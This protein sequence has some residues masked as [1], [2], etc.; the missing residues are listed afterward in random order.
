MQTRSWRRALFFTSTLLEKKSLFWLKGQTIY[1]RKR[2]ISKRH[3]RLYQSG[4]SRNYVQN[5]R[6]W[7]SL[8][9]EGWRS[10]A[11]IQIKGLQGQRRSPGTG[12]SK[13]RCGY[14]LPSCLLPKSPSWRN[15]NQEVR[16]S[17][18]TRT[19]YR[20]NLWDGYDFL[21]KSLI[22]AYGVPEEYIEGEISSQKVWSKGELFYTEKDRGCLTWKGKS[23][24][25]S[26]MELPQVLQWK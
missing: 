1:I 8:R 9:I 26:M 12:S 4:S 5:I 3:G 22:S 15:H 2:S 19:C 25:S 10:S 24:Y 7:E 11:C 21:N 20:R 13:R 14:R 23:S 6:N 18:A 17:W 16:F